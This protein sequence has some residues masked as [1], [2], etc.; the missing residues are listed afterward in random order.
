MVDIDPYR[1]NRIMK[2]TRVHRQHVVLTHNPSSIEPGQTL[3]I[4]FPNLGEHDVIVPGSFFISFALNLKGEKDKARSVVPNIGRK[5][6]KMFKIYFEGNE[7]LSINN[8]DE[9]MT[10]R[11]LWMSKKEK[12]KRIFQG[13]HTA[14]GLKL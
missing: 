6:I 14:N 9:I 1:S 11:D 12:P 5:I 3:Q 8:Y 10:Y 2:A 13:L 4:R 7:V